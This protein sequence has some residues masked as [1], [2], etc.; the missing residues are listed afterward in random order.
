MPIVSTP[1]RFGLSALTCAIL[2]LAPLA[3][4]ALRAADAPSPCADAASQ[5]A[6]VRIA[7]KDRTSV[8]EV[9]FAGSQQWRMAMQ[10]IAPI[11]LP[12]LSPES[13]FLAYVSME[14]GK[15]TLWLQAISTGWRD[16]LAVLE[17][18]PE[19]LCFDASARVIHV[20]ARSKE[21]K[22][23]DFADSLKRVLRQ[24]GTRPAQ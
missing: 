3:P 1:N 13:D 7:R 19:D 12:R 4:L 5:S 18:T 24:P 11:A 21:A 9:F 20:V 6:N 22:D 16:P 17:A 2:A 8:V 23:Y 14:T 10:S 15:P